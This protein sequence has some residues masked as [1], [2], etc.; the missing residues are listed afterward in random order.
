MGVFLWRPRKEQVILLMGDVFPF[1]AILF[2]RPSTGA[3]SVPAGVPL[4]PTCANRG[5]GLLRRSLL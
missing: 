2:D 1:P 5:P 4:Y 3:R